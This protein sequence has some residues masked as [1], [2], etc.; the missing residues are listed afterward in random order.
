[1]ARFTACTWPAVRLNGLWQWVGLHTWGAEQL[2]FWHPWMKPAIN[3]HTLG[4]CH[5][6]DHL[7]RR[8]PSA[9]VKLHNKH[10]VLNIYPCPNVSARAPK[11][12]PLRWRVEDQPCHTGAHMWG[13]LR[14]GPGH[15]MKNVRQASNWSN[16]FRG[17]GQPPQHQLPLNGSDGQ[18]RS[19]EA[20]QLPPPL[21]PSWIAS[22]IKR[23]TAWSSPGQPNPLPVGT[24]SPRPH[25]PGGDG[26]DHASSPAVG[27]GV[28]TVLLF[29]SPP[30]MFTSTAQLSGLL[31]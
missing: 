6:H 17:R 10:P 13:I 23:S 15:G 31:R 4:G 1:M 21:Q 27:G 16:Q 5:C 12:K 30:K 2:L 8:I 14:P 18:R 24:R 28:P 11:D 9:T 22:L 26:E 7:A 20:A 19:G 29:Q 25:A 3:T